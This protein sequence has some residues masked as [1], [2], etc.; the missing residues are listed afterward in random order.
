VIRRSIHTT[1]KSMC[2][3][4]K[5]KIINTTHTIDGDTIFLRGN[6]NREKSLGG[7]KFTITC[8]F[9]GITCVYWYFFELGLD[10]RIRKSHFL[11]REGLFVLNSSPLGGWG[12]GDMC[13]CTIFMCEFI[14]TAA[15]A[16]VMVEIACRKFR[17]YP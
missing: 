14:A 3:R 16:G 9:A 5:C 6:L 7:R 1:N 4:C 11:T 12:R 2:L 10:R 13:N 17:N 15:I 8:Q